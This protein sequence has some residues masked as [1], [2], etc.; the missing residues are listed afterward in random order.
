MRSSEEFI[1]GGTQGTRILG[2]AWNS[3]RQDSSEH[4]KYVEQYVECKFDLFTFSLELIMANMM[5][6]AET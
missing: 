2:A 6:E 4:N 3:R 5:K 1:G